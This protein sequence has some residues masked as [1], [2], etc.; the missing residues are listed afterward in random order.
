MSFQN[1]KYCFLY[2]PLLKSHC[3]RTKTK[4]AVSRLS[5]RIF[6]AALLP[7]CCVSGI[8]KT[9]R[10]TEMWSS[11]APLLCLGR[12]TSSP[13]TLAWIQSVE[14]GKKAINRGNREKTFNNG[15]IL[16][17]YIHTATSM[18]FGERK[19]T[20]YRL[21]FKLL[22]CYYFIS[23]LSFKVFLAPANSLLSSFS[24]PKLGR[25]GTMHYALGLS[26]LWVKSFI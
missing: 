5:T 24:D 23:S 21:C 11:W 13:G 2:F 22:P 25:L 10:L 16:N 1:W 7:L 17:P 4:Q 3:Y 18:L 9:F 15:Q 12:Y 6:K 19:W 20:V 26:S 8:G 14:Q